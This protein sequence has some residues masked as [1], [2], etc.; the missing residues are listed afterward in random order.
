MLMLGTAAP[1]RRAERNSALYPHLQPIV[2][3]TRERSETGGIRFPREPPRC[4][5]NTVEERPFK[6]RVTCPPIRPGL[7]APCI[8]WDSLAGG[9][10]GRVPS[11]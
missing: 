3:P 8:V 9:M 5:D 4:A 6:D 11:S 2:I 7:Q 10:P 1:G